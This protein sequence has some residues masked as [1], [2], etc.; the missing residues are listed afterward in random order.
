M[1]KLS[2]SDNTTT[3]TTTTT[4]TTSNTLNEEQVEY[5]DDE[6]YYSDYTDS[7][8]SDDDYYDEENEDTVIPGEKSS[9]SM[10]KT[11]Q[12]RTTV[13]EQKYQNKINLGQV[14]RVIDDDSHHHLP[15]SVQNQVREINKKDDKQAIRITDKENRAT[16]EQVLDPRT[17][18]MLFKMINKGVFQEINGCVSTGKEANVYHA[19]AGDGEERAIKVYKTSILVFKDRDRYVTGEFRFRRGYSKHNPRKMVKVWAEKEFRNLN[20]LK[21]AGIPCPTPLLLRNHI[22]VMNFIGKDGYAAPRLKDANIS[23]DKYGPLYLDCIKMMRTLFHK[24]RL[25]H[26]DL[27]EYNI[28]YYKSSLYIIDVSQSVEHDHP[29]SLDFLRMD[30][31]NITDFFRKKNVLTMYIK[32]LFEFI[33][34]ITINDDNIDQYLETMRE[35]IQSRG[36]MTDEQKIQENVFRN[37]FIPRTLDQIVD[38]EKD[39]RLAKSGNA[40]IFYQS[41]TGLTQN[42]QGSIKNPNVLEEDK[43]GK[44]VKLEDLPKKER[45]KLVKE[46]NRERRKTKVPKHIKKL[47]KKRKAEK[48]AN[49]NVEPF[50]TKLVP[51]NQ[52]LV[53]FKVSFFDRTSGKPLN[54]AIED[55]TLDSYR[56]ISTLSDYDLLNLSIIFNSSRIFLV[57]D[58]SES[59]ILPISVSSKGTS[60]QL[61]IQF[62]SS[63]I[64]SSGKLK[65]YCRFFAGYYNFLLS[66]PFGYYSTNGVNPVL[67]NKNPTLDYSLLSPVQYKIDPPR[68]SD[69]PKI[70][71]LKIS[72]IEVVNDKFLAQGKI[73]LL[74]GEGAAEP[75]TINEITINGASSPIEPV[76][77]NLDSS[78]T[79]VTIELESQG[80]L[81][82]LYEYSGTP[83]EKQSHTDITLLPDQQLDILLEMLSSNQL[84]LYKMTPNYELRLGILPSTTTK[85]TIKN[86][87]FFMF[88]RIGSTGPQIDD[89]KLYILKGVVYRLFNTYLKCPVGSKRSIDATQQS[90]HKFSHVD[91]KKFFCGETCVSPQRKFNLKFTQN[92]LDLLS[93][94]ENSE[95]LESNVL[96]QYDLL[97]STYVISYGNSIESTSIFQKNEF[98][99]GI[100]P[101]TNYNYTHIFL[102]MACNQ[103]YGSMISN[104]LS[105]RFRNPGNQFYNRIPFYSQFGKNKIISQQSGGEVIHTSVVFE[106]NF[107]KPTIS[108]QDI[109]FEM[110]PISWP[111]PCDHALGLKIRN[112]NRIQVEYLVQFFG[113][114]KLDWESQSIIIPAN[115]EKDIRFDMAIRDYMEDI[116]VQ[117]NISIVKSSYW[118]NLTPI[119]K[120]LKLPIN[121]GCNIPKPCDPLI[122]QP[123]LQILEVSL[124]EENTILVHVEN[125]GQISGEY[126]LI[127]KCEN[128]W[129]VECS[130]TPSSKIN[131]SQNE[132]NQLQLSFS[133]QPTHMEGV[134]VDFNLEFKILNPDRCW[135]NQSTTRVLVAPAPHNKCLLQNFIEFQQIE[136]G[137]WATFN[138]THFYKDVTI[139]LFNNGKKIL[140]SFLR[141]ESSYFG[142]GVQS[143]PVSSR[144]SNKLDLT[145]YAQPNPFNLESTI[146]FEMGL[147]DQDCRNGVTPPVSN[148]IL[149][150]HPFDK[151]SGTPKNPILEGMNISISNAGWINGKIDVVG[152][153]QTNQDGN[154]KKYDSKLSCSGLS[155]SSMCKNQN[156]RYVNCQVSSEFS[157]TPNNYLHC[158]MDVCFEKGPNDCWDHDS[159]PDKCIHKEFEIAMPVDPCHPSIKKEVFL[160][161]TC[162]YYK[163]GNDRSYSLECTVDNIGDGNGTI[164][165]SL[166]GGSQDGTLEILKEYSNQCQISSKS[167]CSFKYDIRIHPKS[168]DETRVIPLTFTSKIEPQV[169]WSSEGKTILTEVVFEY[170]KCPATIIHTSLADYFFEWVPLAEGY[171][172]IERI[173][174]KNLGFRGFIQSTKNDSTGTFEKNVLDLDSNGSDVLIFNSTHDKTIVGKTIK[175]RIFLEVMGEICNPNG[176][177]VAYELKTTILGPGLIPIEQLLFRS[178]G[179]NPISNSLVLS[180]SI[181]LPF[182]VLLIT[183]LIFF[184]PW[185]KKQKSKLEPKKVQ[186]SL[187]PVAPIVETA[188]Q[189]EINGYICQG[190][191]SNTPKQ[192]AFQLSINCLV[193][194]C[195]LKVCSLCFNNPKSMQ[196]L[197]ANRPKKGCACYIGILNDLPPQQSINEDETNNNN[198][199][200]N[201]INNHGERNS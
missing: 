65:F 43:D 169:C 160:N 187:D 9:L 198:N 194:E 89:I 155:T 130:I 118:T 113:P 45:K 97:K 154:G 178:S 95:N 175:T 124:Q 47:N 189:T 192:L 44:P 29:H 63:N 51:D 152:I 133:I 59:V 174:V 116:P 91:L 143:I 200:N 121:S 117:L 185:Y 21:T 46:L 94:D 162:N 166:G 40:D 127:A 32:E 122:K 172:L 132:K 126:E 182:V 170:Q 195:G 28:L 141:W 108:D 190:C 6:E 24:C 54:M 86:S 180:L 149:I 71:D 53:S 144:E 72:T 129:L 79:N 33:T 110:I 39:L 88:T 8:Y 83:D 37:A 92:G 14:K 55:S 13:L 12:P 196:T 70:L 85:E 57:D 114:V 105:T 74:I 111:N 157:P 80:V 75:M 25:V 176:I 36:E 179:G 140:D 23:Q 151:C 156:G 31:A 191:Y 131:L 48:F 56:E 99:S 27:S 135:N 93:I 96:N 186:K 183:G 104:E 68:P 61:W 171:S 10:N 119:T 100:I 20:R 125:N 188:H 90:F 115:D 3:T 136:Q 78:K 107:I 158:S 184:I 76:K 139:N 165:V 101:L 77:I 60:N 147:N 134:K 18:L 5:Y 153:L 73:Q 177:G 17:R 201:N 67:I 58:N 137:Q 50:N 35:K 26:A 164:Q 30:C 163:I 173:H 49:V 22:L 2:I 98:E 87:N 159:F 82:I 102:N 41:V 142:S 62:Q 4:S 167:F 168:N 52:G 145:I 138:G 42:L 38:L 69:K 128:K 150:D 106:I 120:S 1:D 11:L 81:P 148:K 193:E 112:Q 181:A 15:N 66:E 34:D 197:M 146:K 161:N 84:E 64:P 123:N 199:I 16:T 103:A 19:V 7:D 109:Q